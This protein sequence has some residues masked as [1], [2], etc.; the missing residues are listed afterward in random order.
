MSAQSFRTSALLALLFVGA[1]V[2]PSSLRAQS[3]DASD[4]GNVAA[5]VTTVA[6]PASTEAVVVTPA[7][8]PRIAP[9]GISRP[10]PANP[11]GLATPVV[12]DT[13]VGAGP[14]L[15]LMGVGAAAVVIGLMIGGNGGTI[16]AL[17]GGVLGLVGLYRFLR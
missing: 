9:A 7:A 2:G 3:A 8:G 6:T 14:D 16:V 12:D 10:V 11:L 5:P 4:R 17:G 13:H 1:T 15:A